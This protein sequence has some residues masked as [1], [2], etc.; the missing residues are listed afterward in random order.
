VGSPSID[1]VVAGLAVTQALVQ[2]IFFMDLGGEA[3]PR[4]RLGVLIFMVGVVLIVVFGSLWIMTNLNYHM[5]PDQVNHYLNG[6]DG[7]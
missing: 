1:R 7:L 4:W 2:L 5:T 3:K 6:Q